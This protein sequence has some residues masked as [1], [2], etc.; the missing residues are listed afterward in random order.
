M[1]RE[2]TSYR[3]VNAGMRGL[4]AIA[5]FAAVTSPARAAETPVR[6]ETEPP[7][8]VKLIKA[9][10]KREV[11]PEVKMDTVLRCEDG[12][13]VK[14]STKTATSSTLARKPS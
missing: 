2:R 4:F 11:A 3:A 10:A 1:E 9:V 12:V 5:V 13:C 7:A 14:V 6:V 8:K